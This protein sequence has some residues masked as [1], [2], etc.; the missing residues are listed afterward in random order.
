LRWVPY[1]E[2]IGCVDENICGRLPIVCGGGVGSGSSCAGVHVGR[3]LAGVRGHSP[4]IYWGSDGGV[5]VVVTLVCVHMGGYWVRV[6]RTK[7]NVSGY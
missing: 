6:V 4:V 7:T 1:G 2:S 3:V 5:V